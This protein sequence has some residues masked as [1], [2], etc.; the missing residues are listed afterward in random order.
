MINFTHHTLLKLLG[1]NLTKDN[2]KICN[3]AVAKFVNVKAKVWHIMSLPIYFS[4][5]LALFP[6]NYIMSA[7]NIVWFILLL[8]LQALQFVKTVIT[9]ARLVPLLKIHMLPKFCVER[10]THIL[11]LLT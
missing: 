9:N 5:F 8:L 11:Q 10:K 2:Y 3:R 1:R 7:V 6:S 4:Y